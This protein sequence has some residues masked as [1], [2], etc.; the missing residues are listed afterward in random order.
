MQGFES[1]WRSLLI[2]SVVHAIS[3]SRSVDPTSRAPAPPVPRRAH[4]RG[5]TAALTGGGGSVDWQVQKEQGARSGEKV[6]AQLS[7]D[8]TGNPFSLLVL[9]DFEAATWN[10]PSRSRRSAAR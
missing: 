3:C 8:A 4:P 9:D 2:L 5:F 10:L 6:V 7:E 1:P